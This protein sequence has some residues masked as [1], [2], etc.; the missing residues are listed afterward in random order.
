MSKEK[1]SKSQKLDYEIPPK[2][3]GFKQGTHADHLKRIRT[4]LREVGGCG[5][6]LDPNL[7]KPILKPAP[8]EADKTPRPVF[9]P[10]VPPAGPR[11]ET[12]EARDQRLE[13]HELARQ[14]YENDMEVY[15]KDNAR[16]DRERSDHEKSIKARS[17]WDKEQELAIGQFRTFHEKHRYERILM[18]EPFKSEKTLF[19][20][21]IAAEKIYLST[22]QSGLQSNYWLERAHTARISPDNGDSPTAW[23]ELHDEWK[24]L[25]ETASIMKKTFESKPE[26]KPTETLIDTMLSCAVIASIPTEGTSSM[27]HRLQEVKGNL[28]KNACD[29]YDGH[30][31][32]LA[33]LAQIVQ[34]TETEMEAS[35]SHAIKAN[36]VRDISQNYSTPKPLFHTISVTKYLSIPH[37]EPCITTLNG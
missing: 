11:N 31:G 17:E 2:I 14:N 25:I 7:T 30:E 29:S 36:R 5:P 33:K 21:F 32:L 26:R 19:N 23:L 12:A 13:D 37:F 24:K 1:S 20:A 28:E 27:Y 34:T 22:D 9:V 8:D 3:T 16:Y 6:Q 10:R 35:D 18:T 15:F 4:Y